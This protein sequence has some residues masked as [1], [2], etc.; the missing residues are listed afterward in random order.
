MCTFSGLYR[1]DIDSSSE[2]QSTRISADNLPFQPTSMTFDKNDELWLAN[3]AS[4]SDLI[5][6][7]TQTGGWQY[8][9]GPNSQT[10]ITF[11]RTINDLTTF[12][13]IDD[14]A[15]DPDT[16]GDGI[17][18]S[19]DS[20]PTSAGKAFEQFTP[21]K[22]GWGTVAFEDLWPSLGD[23]DFNDTAVNY[24]FVA[25]LNAQ[26]KAVQLDIHYQVTSDGAGLTN[27]FGIEFENLSPLKVASV[28]GLKLQENYIEQASNGLE[29]NQENAV[30]IL[31]DNH[32]QVVNQLATVSIF[33]TEPITTA[34]LGNAPFNPF[35]IAGK[36]RT[37]E[38]HLPNK[39]RTSLG[40]ELSESSNINDDFKTD[41]GLP[42]AINI[43]HDFKVPKEKISIMNAYNNF[44]N[45]AE[46]GGNQN[47]DWYKDNPG[48]RNANN[49][50]L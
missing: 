44:A 18:D 45:W 2:Y 13:I 40:Q 17:K 7:D 4:N 3:N 30:V 16:D 47:L 41:T 37:H 15:I 8:N 1:L 25:V 10:D 43:I 19:N 11:D 48:N 21:S 39:K 35:L 36:R 50:K 22:Y 27:A 46:T 23:Y 49:I 6:M 33:F 28:T 20:F 14:E 34:E 9:Y 5:I 38:I 12:K 29:A 32:G 24:R 26:N 31:F 42:W